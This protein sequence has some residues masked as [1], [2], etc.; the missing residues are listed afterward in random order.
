[1]SRNNVNVNENN[2]NLHLRSKDGIV[3]M[4]TWKEAKNYG[5]TAQTLINIHQYKCSDSR[6]KLSRNC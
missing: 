3:E 1:M 4:V 2:G 5:T 6:H